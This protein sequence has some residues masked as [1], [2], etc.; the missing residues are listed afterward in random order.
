MGVLHSSIMPIEN[1]LPLIGQFISLR[2]LPLALDSD[3]EN[4]LQN[5]N[6]FFFEM[7]KSTDL[8]PQIPL[9]ILICSL[10]GFHNTSL[11]P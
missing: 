11:D 2:S 10:L 7:Y 8:F 6:L 4:C 3:Y 9:Q 1:L 5:P